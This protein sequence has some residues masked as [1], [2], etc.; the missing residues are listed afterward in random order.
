MRDIYVKG[1]PIA[2]I[3]IG[4]M[5]WSPAPV[6]ASDGCIGAACRILSLVPPL[7]APITDPGRCTGPGCRAV[8]AEAASSP[9]NT[10]VVL[11]SNDPHTIVLPGTPVGPGTSPSAPLASS[12]GA[13]T[14]SRPIL[15]LPAPPT[16]TDP[17][18]CTGPGCPIRG[19]T[20]PGL[21]TGPGCS[22]VVL[23]TTGGPSSSSTILILPG[24]D[25][26][27]IVVPGTLVGP[28]P[29][30]LG[31]RSAT[32]APPAPP[33]NSFASAVAQPIVPETALPRGGSPLSFDSG[34]HDCDIPFDEL[35]TRAPSCATAPSAD[36]RRCEQYS[37]SQFTEIVAL[38][39][40]RGNEWQPL[41]TGTLIS[42]RWVVTAAHCFLGTQSTAAAAGRTG[43]DLVFT[44]PQLTG[45]RISA[46]NIMTLDE[47]GRDRS[48]EQA[49]VYRDYG[50][51]AERQGVVFDDDLA[52]IQLAMAY[53]AETI[54]PARLAQA[55]DVQTH[56]TL[57]GYGFSNADGGTLGR[58]NL[59]WPP[60]LE[61]RNNQ[62]FFVPGRDGQHRSAFCQGDSGGPVLAG[63]NRGC[64]RTDRV[65]EFRP[66]Y[67][68][69][70]VS[71]NVIQQPGS[72]SSA[73]IWASACM[74]AEK[75]AMQDI[76]K[77]ARR[78]WICETT[79]REAGGC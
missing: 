70:I 11:P 14:F 77:E 17:G 76:T 1:I 62:F 48:L 26:R 12:T 30:P 55:T 58:F 66:R 49:I 63:R 72:G 19:I 61:R 67:I 56:A 28:D 42:P 40:L 68:Q 38:K 9:G 41:C 13:A 29:S 59:T 73:M 54:E 33:A 16:I 65:H 27:T 23:P 60:A 46:E 57:A 25:P 10:I 5:C 20:M 6:P 43:V 78:D 3:V 50:G 53:P 37:R 51:N 64:R 75:M 35:A 45:Y 31:P 74:T 24:N 79:I 4:G 2:T 15:S 34:L 8:A 22:T 7:V 69:G 52:L 39:V 47:A 21:C 18:R 44:A 71:Y 32:E 36:G